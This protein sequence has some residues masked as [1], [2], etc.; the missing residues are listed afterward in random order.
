MSGRKL[1][2][3]LTILENVG[4]CN[5]CIC[6]T[7]DYLLRIYHK[8]ERKKALQWSQKL[9]SVERQG[10]TRKDERRE[11]MYG[12]TSLFFS[13]SFWFWHKEI[14]CSIPIS[15]KVPTLQLD[16]PHTANHST[17]KY[18]LLCTNATESL[19]SQT[20]DRIRWGWGGV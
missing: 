13:F 12:W 17:D 16:P 18:K 20:E 3:T 10:K 1:L 8:S 14:C 2:T 11:I 15:T 7:E 5:A 19:K 9:L 4:L 6:V